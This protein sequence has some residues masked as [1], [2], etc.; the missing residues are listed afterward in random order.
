MGADSPRKV[1]GATRIFFDPGK[2]SCRQLA[3][4]T[5]N[6][7]ARQI[8]EVINKS[9]QWNRADNLVGQMEHHCITAEQ[10]RAND[11]ADFYNE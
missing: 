5:P 11:R 1:C 6:Y 10:F 7:S 8:D 9:W 3:I 4:S 2:R